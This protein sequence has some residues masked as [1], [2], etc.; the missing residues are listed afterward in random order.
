MRSETGQTTYQRCNPLFKNMLCTLDSP[1]RTT[2]YTSWVAICYLVGAGRS[3]LVS[4]FYLILIACPTIH[5]LALSVRYSSPFY[6]SYLLFG[7]N[8]ELEE[9]DC[10]ALGKLSEIGPKR[11]EINLLTISGVH[12]QF[13]STQV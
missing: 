13:F 8:T 3:F 11:G 6:C 1:N 5:T 4:C 2:G 7:I 10:G 12:G 9:E